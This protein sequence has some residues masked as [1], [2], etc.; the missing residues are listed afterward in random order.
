[1]KDCG[2]LGYNYPRIQLP[3]AIFHEIVALNYTNYRRCNHSIFFF[4]I[5]FTYA[6]WCNELW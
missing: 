6:S 2:I 3:I 1:M 4:A 5:G